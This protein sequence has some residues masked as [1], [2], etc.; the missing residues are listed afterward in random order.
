MSFLFS[1]F[2]FSLFFWSQ[3]FA[4]ASSGLGDIGP[5]CFLFLFLFSISV[6][7]RLDTLETKESADHRSQ[8]NLCV[9]VCV[10]W[11]FHSEVSLDYANCAYTNRHCPARHHRVLERERAD[12]VCL[13]FVFLIVSHSSLEFYFYLW[14]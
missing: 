2:F 1:F 12:L 6:V 7:F 13:V 5:A 10:T 4:S 3:V 11:L 8:M 14:S 9:C